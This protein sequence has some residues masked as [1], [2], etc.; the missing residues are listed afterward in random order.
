MHDDLF[1]LPY[2]SITLSIIVGPRIVD[3]TFNVIPESDLFRVKL[4]IPWLDSMN[5]ILLP[6]FT[7]V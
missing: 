6:L 4:G 5:G 1:I 3:T 7:N 2:G